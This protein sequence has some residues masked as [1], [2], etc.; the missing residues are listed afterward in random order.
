MPHALGKILPLAFALDLRLHR[1]L[2]FDLIS[3]RLFIHHTLIVVSSQMSNLATAIAGSGSEPTLAL[4]CR[5]ADIAVGIDLHGV[6][7]TTREDW[8]GGG[9]GGSGGSG[10]SESK[11]SPPV[12]GKDK[13]K[14]KEKDADKS[15]S[16]SGGSGSSTRQKSVSVLK[17][18]RP[19]FTKKKNSASKGSS[20][21]TNDSGNN[22]GGANGNAAQKT[23]EAYEKMLLTDPLMIE[24]KRRRDTL[25][26]DWN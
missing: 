24:V 22:N 17:V 14:E 23:A 8:K 16:R 11:S 15:Q 4:G 10:S 6:G 9:G 7:V 12:N 2:F 5:D 26:D 20:P 19:L 3:L 18:T 25:D 21:T 13:A 1:F